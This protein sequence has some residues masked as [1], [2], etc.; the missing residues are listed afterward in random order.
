MCGAKCQT[1]KA[2]RGPTWSGRLICRWLLGAKAILVLNYNL[3]EA[4][5]LSGEALLRLAPLIA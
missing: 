4:A 3:H 1:R 2:L 5:D